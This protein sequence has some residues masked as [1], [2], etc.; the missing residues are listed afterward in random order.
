MK[1]TER[2]KKVILDHLEKRASQDALFY[3]TYHQ[4]GKNIDDCIK[5]ILNTVRKSECNGFEDAEI[6]NMAVHYYDEK[7]IE[8]G[9][10]VNASV[11]INHKIELTPEEKA[12]AREKAVREVIEEEKRKMRA[13]TKPATKRNVDEDK[14][15]QQIISGDISNE[16]G[17]YQQ[18]S[19]F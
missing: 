9:K 17:P 16:T 18:Q 10:E 15:V 14:K 6:F 3:E 8:V 5:Y 2:F 13:T 1:G 7:N 11:K 4:E 19:L 12:E